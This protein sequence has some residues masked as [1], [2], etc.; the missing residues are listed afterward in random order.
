[1]RKNHLLRNSLIILGVLAALTGVGFY[2]YYNNS[3][4]RDMV[5][6]FGYSPK[7]VIAD[8]AKN[9]DLTDKARNIFY[10]SRPEL[11]DAE[12]FNEHCHSHN[13]KIA[14][15]G[16]YTNKTIYLYDYDASELSGVTESTSAHELLHAAWARLS[17]NEKSRLAPE[18]NSVYKTYQDALSEDLSIYENAD[19]L[20][21][22]HSRIGTQIPFNNLPKTL[23]DHYKEYFKNYDRVIEY[24]ND[25][26]EPFRELQTEQEILKSELEDEQADIDYRSQVYYEAAEKLSRQI[27]EFNNCANTQGCFRTDAAFNAR[28]AILV[29]E[30][31]RLEDEY[32]SINDAIQSYNQKVE[33]YNKS[34]L[35]T[36]DLESTI[37]SNA[38]L[39]ERINL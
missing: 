29:N 39:K 14:V 7:T 6:N 28:R 34:V 4:F 18:L 17:A 5:S 10:A 37:N 8:I 12:N 36:Q 24:Y 22:L 21:E 20:D 33:K 25:Y 2:A 13:E 32:N 1:M 30:Q 15:L 3:D 9:L 16:C 11:E 38:K 31:K 19:Q 27:D 35:R 26:I 23:Q